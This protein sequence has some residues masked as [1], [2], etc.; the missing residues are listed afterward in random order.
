[1][2]R[3]TLKKVS[4]TRESMEVGHGSHIMLY[5]YIITAV[6]SHSSSSRLQLIHVA[7]SRAHDL[8]IDLT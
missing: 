4:W 2:I 6:D 5:N 1:M 3:K 7:N 8:Y